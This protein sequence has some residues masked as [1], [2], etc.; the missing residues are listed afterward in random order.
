MSRPSADTTATSAPKALAAASLLGSVPAP[1]TT[2]GLTTASTSGSK[3]IPN[4]T[5][6]TI[7]NVPGEPDVYSFF[8]SS[9]STWQYI[10]VDPAT[11]KA[12]VIDPVLDYNPASGKVTTKTA[13]GL[14]SFVKDNGLDVEMLLETHAHADHLTSAQYLKHKLEASSGHP[15]PV[16]IGKRITAVQERFGKVYGIPKERLEN[17]FDKYWE[18]DEHFNI[19]QL[20]CKVVHLPGHTPDHVGYMCGKGLFVGDTIF[21]PDVGSA[22]ADF[23]GGSPT[24]LFNSISYILSLPPD[25]R[26][27]AGHDYPPNASGDIEAIE[28]ARCW[29]LVSDQ[30]NSNV[31]IRARLQEIHD[32]NASTVAEASAKG[33]EALSKELEQSL[34]E[35][36]I[37]WRA[38]RDSTL[39]APRLLHPS[40][41]VNVCAGKFPQGD[42]ERGRWLRIPVQG[43]PEGL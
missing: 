39:G 30:R 27:Y 17:A 10:V 37:T 18:D 25:T 34:M 3:L 19:G 12:V 1:A 23:P 16:A 4:P 36:F 14:L 13:D 26:I 33:G 32:A 35:S 29:S 6:T 21:Y 42:T 15:V 11:K 5:C 40:L 43:V 31:H 9:T 7:P 8:E 2:R 38:N 41:Q 20:E 22:R 28:G 24:D